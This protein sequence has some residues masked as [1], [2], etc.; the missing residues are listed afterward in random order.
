MGE[1]AE[2][3]CLIVFEQRLCLRLHQTPMMIVIDSP[4]HAPST[5]PETVSLYILQ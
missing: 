5:V 2:R 4:V 1:R 3:V